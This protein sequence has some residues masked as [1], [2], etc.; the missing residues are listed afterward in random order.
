MTKLD[1]SVEVL[2]ENVEIADCRWR[3]EQIAADER[4]KASPA[5]AQAKEE[6]AHAVRCAFDAG[7]PK[8]RLN[9]A[10]STKSRSIVNGILFQTDPANAAV[11]A[12]Y[13]R[14]FQKWLGRQE[15]TES[16]QAAT[17]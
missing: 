6:R 2:L 12:E 10:L 8:A 3:L 16:G 14:G 1:A 15:Q 17:A 9:K 13:E 7:A 4:A 5:I 11:R